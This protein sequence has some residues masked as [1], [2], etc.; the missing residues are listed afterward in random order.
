M[1]EAI[2]QHGAVATPHGGGN[3][4]R[5][6]LGTALLGGLVLAAISWFLAH[7]F[8]Q[9]DEPKTSNQVTTITMVGWAVG[10][11]IGIGAFNGP[12]RWMLGHDETHEDET[13]LAGKGQGVG[14]YFRF[15]TD[16]KVVGIQYLVVT[17][18]LLG[19]G[20][21]LAMLIR[22]DLIRPN[23][24]FLGP[25]T[26]NAVVG[27][28]GLC[29]I[30]ATI[31]MITGPFGNFIVPIMIGARDMAFPRLNALSLWLLVSMLPILVSAA[32]LGG[33]PTG[34]SG[35]APLADQGP[36][37]MNAYLIAIIIFAMS[38]AIAGANITTTILTMRARGM[39]WNR[40]PI[41]VWGVLASVG[42]AIPA[43]PM[44]MTSMIFLGVDR[45][46][47]G[48]FYVA[49]SG[50]NPWLYA[51][52]FWLMGHPEVYVIVLPAV[53]ALM[54]L[55][56]VFAR[57]PLFSYTGAVLAIVGIVGLSMMVWAHHMYASGWAPDLNGPFML[58]TE[59]ISVPTGVLFLV[60]IGTIWRGR[61]WTTLP[62]MSTYAMLWNFIIGGVTGIYLSDVPADYDLHGSM[63]V[64]AHFHY[65]L[66]GA[67]LTGAIGA[68]AYWFPK[69]T[70][71]MLNQ[72]AGFVSFWLV[73]IGFNVTFM[74][75]FTVGL[76]GQPRRIEHYDSLF[77]VGNFVSTM[78]AY[79]IGVG[80]LILLYAVV[81]SWRH[82]AV[83]PAN[84]WGGKTLEWTVPNPIPLENFEVMPVVIADPYGYGEG[85]PSSVHTEK[86]RRE[87]LVGASP[88]SP[89]DTIG[90]RV[91]GD[92]S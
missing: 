44:F 4:R 16:H 90:S 46:V 18:V 34:W 53:A 9:T 6:N 38:S 13:Y 27:L 67:G 5:L 32:F 2:V 1:S 33:I 63:F 20:G 62:M 25:Q 28:H 11:M 51:N 23:S 88:G 79:V 80:M 49:S 19:I 69:M 10:F 52:L 56:P 21:T 82:G 77:A 48:S 60:V 68:L 37:G 30:L 41:F 89:G 8:L 84:P 74:G 26:Y 15:T 81:S 43:F 12:W 65:T 39:T 58:T 70:G 73:Q 17:M 14:R 66:M 59:M 47:D 87:A 54:E 31:I 76:A 40:T 50:G 42:L 24:E 22:T 75:L 86:E 78:G 45:T 71:R 57:K 92:R 3:M 35:Y 61:I 7:H 29:M 72:R 83:A 55:T 85:D 36:P 91:D 64:T